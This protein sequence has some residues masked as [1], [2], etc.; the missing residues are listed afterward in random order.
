MIL[1]EFSLENLKKGIN[2]IQSINAINRTK[3]NRFE[4]V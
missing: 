3:K 2:S 4:I 1:G